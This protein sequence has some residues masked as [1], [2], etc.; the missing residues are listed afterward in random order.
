M[1]DQNNGT[2]HLLKLPDEF[3]ENGAVVVGEGLSQFIQNE[4]LGIGG[5]GAGQFHHLARFHVH[6]AGQPLEGNGGKSPLA[7]GLIGSLIN[8][9]VVDNSEAGKTLGIAEEDVDS[10]WKVGDEPQLLHD[11]GY[12]AG[13]GIQWRAGL[14]GR[15]V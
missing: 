4:D 9:P 14:I 11:N 2:A 6:I 8:L 3:I 12:A 13:G 7:Q 1:G 5:Q 15:S 10:G